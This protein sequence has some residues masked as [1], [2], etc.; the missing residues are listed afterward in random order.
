MRVDFA[1]AVSALLDAEP[2]SIFITGDLGYN[3]L[4]DIAARLGDRFINAGVAE[5]NMIGMSAGIALAGYRP[6]VYSIATFL[7]YRCLEQIRNDICLHNL[8]VRL[9]GN[10]GGYTYG[11]MGSTHHAVEDLA[12]VKA[13]PNMRLY[14][15]TS[16]GQVARCVEAASRLS[17][18]SY[19]R[20]AISGFPANDAPISENA[21]T[22]TRR[23]ATGDRATVIGV[24]HATQIGLTAINSLGLTDVDLFGIATF[25]FDLRED[26]DIVESAERTGRV[27]VL[28]EHYLPGSLA[29]SLALALPRTVSFVA[30]TAE[31]SL[32][33]AYGGTAFH[34]KQCGL[35]PQALVDVVRSGPKA[36]AYA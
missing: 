5:Q 3:A 14:F 17:G 13:L 27:I 11:I 2:A 30:M 32:G 6:W 21:V 29:E 18:P 8:P 15:P 25:P 23:Y 31:Y 9:V 26:R 7:T 12:V 19:L 10:G 22:L 16:G 35:T 36:R 34:L 33:H 1:R 28:D 4:E 24:G 20:L